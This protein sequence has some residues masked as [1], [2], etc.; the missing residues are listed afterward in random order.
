VN[1]AADASELWRRESARLVVALTRIFGIHN[2]SLAEDVVQEAFCRALEHWQLVGAPDNPAAWLMTTARNRALDI[3]R[4]ERT[5]RSFALELGRLLDSEWTRAPLIDEAFDD[6]IIADEQLRMMFSCCHPRLSEAAR[7]ALI[8]NILCG[9]H[10][11]EIASALLVGRAAVEKRLTRGKKVLAEAKRLFDLDAADFEARL[12][13]VRTALYLLFNEGYHGASSHAVV[14]ASLCDE[15]LRLTLLLC[16]HARAGTPVTRAL[17]ALMSLHAARLPARVNDAGELSALVDQDRT[18]WDARLL[19][20]GL[21]LFE[22][23]ASGSELSPYH[24]ESAIAVAHASAPT[25]EQTDWSAIVKLYDRMSTMVRSPVVALN[26][27][28]A[29]AQAE[30]PERGICE[31]QAVPQPERLTRYPFYFAALADLECKRGAHDLARRH[32]ERALT[33]ARN[34]AERSFLRARLAAV[35]RAK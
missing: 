3:V 24:I 13:T 8:L 26:R 22:Q 34:D 4:R 20:Q 32:Y 7:V 25:L 29:L 2:L 11:D 21:A 12:S 18:R 28:I 30:G 14:R 9:F 1:T 31:L 27:A 19:A 5:A 6:R 17:A 10:A 35:G 16:E 33:A 15:A 23:S